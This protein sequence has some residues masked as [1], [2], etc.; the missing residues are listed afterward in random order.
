MNTTET[1]CYFRDW[2]LAN[3]AHV[4]LLRIL[5]QGEEIQWFSVYYR[6]ELAPY[7]QVPHFA[8]QFSFP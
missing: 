2:S 3:D 1:T 8:V 7:G 6:T 4:E 5:R